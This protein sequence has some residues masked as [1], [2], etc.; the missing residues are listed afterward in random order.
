M[1]NSRSTDADWVTYSTAAVTKSRADTFYRSSAKDVTRT[2]EK[3]DA[4]EIKLRE[5]R[6]S[7]ANPNSTP[8]IIGLDVTGSMGWLA[9][10]LAKTE[11]PRLIG[12]I[13]EKSPIADPHLMFM[14]IGDAVHPDEQ[15]LQMTQFEADLKIAEQLQGIWLEGKGGGNHFESYDLAWAAAAYKTVSDCWE[16]RKKKGYLFTLG[17]EEFPESLPRAIS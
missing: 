17:D 2:G 12:M 7:A 11:L 1:G 3:V 8:I 10:A 5:S 6:D 4:V 9:E 14:G 13:L 15:P 16:K